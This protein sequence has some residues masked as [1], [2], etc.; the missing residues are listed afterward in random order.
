[1]P[2]LFRTIYACGLRASEARLLRPGDVDT[3]AGVLQIRDAKGG[4]DG[5]RPRG[6][7]RYGGHNYLFEIPDRYR[8]GRAV[9]QN[10]VN[11]ASDALVKVR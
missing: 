3:G 5:P 9:T 4:K 10:A 7:A 8:I 11:H 6:G 2:V 1:M